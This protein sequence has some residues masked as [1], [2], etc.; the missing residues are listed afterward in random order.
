[1]VQPLRLDD[2][3]LVRRERDEVAGAAGAIRPLPVRPAIRA[4][5]SAIHPTTSPRRCPRRRACDQTS[6]RPSCSEAIPPHAV[7][8]SPV[9]RHLSS[10]VHGEWSDT[11]MSM[12]PSTR[13]P[14]SSCGVGGVAIGGQHLNAVPPSGISSAASVR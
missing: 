11:T 4:G 14:Q 10:L 13:P 8:K 9:S 7:P 5:A 3:L 6:G 12:V 2:E 1:V